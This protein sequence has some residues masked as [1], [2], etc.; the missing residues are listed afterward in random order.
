MPDFSN[1]SNEMFTG[2]RPRAFQLIAVLHGHSRTAA[3]QAQE[4]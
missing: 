4:E 3:R 1:R 2:R